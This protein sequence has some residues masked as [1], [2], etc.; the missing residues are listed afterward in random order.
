[1]STK[2]Y[3]NKRYDSLIEFCKAFS[4]EK[5]CINF[6]ERKRWADGVVS[7]YDETSK[8][9]KRGDGLYRCKNTGKNFNVRIGTIFQESKVSLTKWF[10]AIYLLETRSKGISSAQLAKD[11]NLTQK[12][13]WYMLH[14]IRL[15]MEYKGEKFDGEV[16]LDETFVGGKNKNRHSKNK[17][18]NAQGRSFKDKVPVMGLLQRDSNGGGDKVMCFQIN[19]TSWKPLTRHIITHVK[20]NVTLYMDDWQ[21]YRVVNKVYKSSV[22]DHGHGIYVDG[23][24]YTNTIEA[25]WS[26]YCKRPIN[27]TY[28]SISKHHM[29]KYFDEFAWRYNTRKVSFSER[30]DL[31][32]TNIE[33]L[34]THKELIKGNG[35]RRKQTLKQV[36]EMQ[37]A[38]RAVQQAAQDNAA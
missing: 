33:H 1:M 3:F 24:T 7:P 35:N 18:R 22:V 21:G 12:T 36:A 13:A 23:N 9:Y 10:I 5:R 17:I 32:F 31:F 30:F 15:C 38:Q 14:K 28:S 19:D 37:R 8:V 11:L 2:S 16:E 26:N 29:Q 20:R 6:L 27:S 34:V 4:T 25:F